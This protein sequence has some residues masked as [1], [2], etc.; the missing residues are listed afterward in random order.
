MAQTLPL[1]LN[2]LFWLVILL[3][4]MASAWWL[5]RASARGERDEDDRADLDVYADQ[6]TEI[7]RDLAQGRISGM[8][9]EAGR[10]EI[11][12][13][14]VKAR[15]RI[16]TPGPRAN[17][18]VLGVIATGVVV[19]AAGLYAVSGS[20]G[21]ADLP[22][23]ARER[24]LLSRDPATLTQDEILLLLQERARQSPD[25]PQPHAL[26][27]Q[28]LA[29]AGRDADALRAYQAA[30]R[31]APND[32]EA[33]AEAGAILTRL[34]GGKVG[35][36][37]QAAFDAALKINPKSVAAQFYL[38]LVDWQAGRKDAAMSAWARAHKILADQPQS[39]DRLTV[40]VAG[41]ISQLDRGPDSGQPGGP[42]AQGMSAADQAGFIASMVESRVARL[43]A[44]PEDV[45]LRLSVVRVLMM[46]GQNEA[47]R[48]TLLEG[49]ERAEDKSF[50]LALYGVT[51][52][53]LAGSATSQRPPSANPDR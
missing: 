4:L 29:A 3:S 46:T 35:A 47:A 7:D 42:M 53:A 8:A 26:M 43:K 37:A 32:A 16:L 22:F 10:L 5:M 21:R 18:L 52:R 38:G 12:R 49:V 41:A 33:I 45:A 31:R 15:N 23:K 27:G 36:D 44:A 48:K 2:A 39:Q 13:R 30:L 28:V 11:G 34:N 9:A 6:V 24:E 20:P 40:R 17:R 51:A 14:L 1:H 19:L 50:T 25:D